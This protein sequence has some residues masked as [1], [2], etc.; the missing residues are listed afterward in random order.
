MR[1]GR[2]QRVV[3]E[4]GPGGL[5]YDGNGGNEVLSLWDMCLGEANG[6]F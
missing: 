6:T 1:P 2:D 3:Q 5:A 4:R